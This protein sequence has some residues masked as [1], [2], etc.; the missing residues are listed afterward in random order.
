MAPARDRAPVQPGHALR[1]QTADR[2]AAHKVGIETGFETID[3]V[4]DLENRPPMPEVD[5]DENLEDVPPVALVPPMPQE[6]A[7]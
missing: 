5:E 7:Q 2:Y 1:S 6:V 3:E 4:R